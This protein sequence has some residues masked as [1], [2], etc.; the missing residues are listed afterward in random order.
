MTVV[1]MRKGSPPENNL[2]KWYWAYWIGSRDKGQT[3]GM[4]DGQVQA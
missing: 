1:R 4:E 3:Q 2:R